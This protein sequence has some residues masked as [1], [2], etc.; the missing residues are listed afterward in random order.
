MKIILM[1]VLQIGGNREIPA[2]TGCSYELELLFQ[3]LIGSEWLPFLF[4]NV[5][6]GL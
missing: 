6:E 3:L 5:Y 2:N 1:F 4:L